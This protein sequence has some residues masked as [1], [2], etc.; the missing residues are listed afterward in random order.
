MNSGI[1]YTKTTQSTPADSFIEV[2]LAREGDYADCCGSGARKLHANW[3]RVYSH[4]GL[5]GSTLPLLKTDRMG[6]IALNRHGNV[7]AIVASLALT[8]IMCLIYH[9]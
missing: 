4:A 3:T 2:L 6:S 7:R 5:G 8:I 9:S 1:S